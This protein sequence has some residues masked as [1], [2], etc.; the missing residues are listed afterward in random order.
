MSHVISRDTQGGVHH[1]DSGG[2]RRGGWRMVGSRLMETYQA[3]S[4]GGTRRGKVTPRRLP[5]GG[6]GRHQP[7]TGADSLPAE[8]L[9]R[10]K[11][12]LEARTETRQNNAAFERGRALI[13]PPLRSLQALLQDLRHSFRCGGPL[14]HAGYSAARPCSSSNPC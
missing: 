12:A 10:F 14:I 9:S 5:G 2:R 1:T 3:R 8:L 7:R 6:V 13:V 4:L 11:S